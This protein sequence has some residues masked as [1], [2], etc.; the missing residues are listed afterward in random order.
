MHRFPRVK[1]GKPHGPAQDIV[2]K[3]LVERNHTGTLTLSLG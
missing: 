1:A 3:N 2:V